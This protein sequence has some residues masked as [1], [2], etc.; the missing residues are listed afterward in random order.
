VG[1]VMKNLLYF[2]LI[3]IFIGN[4]FAQNSELIKPI[5]PLNIDTFDDEFQGSIR[6]FN[7]P[8]TAANYTAVDTMSNSFGPASS[9]LNPVVYDPVSKI[10]AVVHRGN[11]MTYAQSSGELWWNYSTDMGVSWTRSL[12]SVQNN[13]ITQINARYPSMSIK[14][15]SGSI[16]L[17]D[18]WGVFSWPELLGYVGYGLTIGMEV[19]AFAEI[20]FGPPFYSGGV[21]IFTDNNYIYWVASNMEDADLRLFRTTDYLVIDKIDPPT[22]NSGEFGGSI[23]LGGVAYNGSL[24]VGL[25]AAFTEIIGAGVGKLDTAN[26]PT[27][28]LPGVTGMLLI[29]HKSR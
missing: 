22:W 21:P 27:R 5:A 29:G 3:F 20:D 9:V 10:L 24:Y 16:N 1:G 6:F 15:P 11:A 18:I 19:S 25:T 23:E 14:N 13:F 28:E 2:C 12:T 17:D 4:I 8:T 7:S 26:Q